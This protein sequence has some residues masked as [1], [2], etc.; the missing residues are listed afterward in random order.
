MKQVLE[1]SELH[2]V[3]SWDLEDSPGQCTWMLQPEP[4]Q[5]PFRQIITPLIPEDAWHAQA[6]ATKF[7]LLTSSNS[8]PSQ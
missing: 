3:I 2:S 8:F 6:L 4:S 5:N 1:R 7:M